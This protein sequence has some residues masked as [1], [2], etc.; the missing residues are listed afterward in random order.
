MLERHRHNGIDLSVKRSILYVMSTSSGQFFLM[1]EIFASNFD[2]HDTSLKHKKIGTSRVV[3]EW[4][5]NIQN[6]TYNRGI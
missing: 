3:A 5:M 6:V 1:I 4:P 2:M